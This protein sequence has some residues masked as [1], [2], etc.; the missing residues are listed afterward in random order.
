[1]ITS[2][3]VQN[4]L[5]NVLLVQEIWNLAEQENSYDSLPSNKVFKQFINGLKPFV[6]ELAPLVNELAAPPNNW[7]EDKQLLKLIEVVNQQIIHQFTEGEQN[8]NPELAVATQGI[9]TK[10]ILIMGGVIGLIGI[11]VYAYRCQQ[12]KKA[13]IN[14]KKDK[15]TSTYKQLVLLLVIDAKQL[16]TNLKQDSRISKD[17][18]EKIIADATFAY[19]FTEDDSEGQNVLSAVDCS[20]ED[21]KYDS[22]E[23]VFL[24][25]SLSAKPEITAGKR[26]KLGIR[27]AMQPNKEVEI[28]RLQKL[29]TMRSVKAFHSI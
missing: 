6:N 7:E 19:C 17:V 28:K 10:I 27:E 12:N 2:E 22:E 23:R 26:D 16:D 15:S 14:N 9:A 18:A 5:R 8:M 1:M 13:E 29:Q 20:D 24:Q 11:G 3:D 25:L 21:I 4:I